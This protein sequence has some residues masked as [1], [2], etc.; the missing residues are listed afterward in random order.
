[1]RNES[2]RTNQAFALGRQMTVEYYECD[3]SVLADGEL[4]EKIFLRAAEKSGAHI[5][6]SNFHNFE[7]QGVSGVVVISESH[8]AVHAWPEHDYAAVDIFTCGESI[9]FEVAIKA[10]Q[11]GMNAESVIVSGVMNRGIVSN[12]GME[13]LVPL[14]EDDSTCYSLSWKS[15][16]E[17]VSASGISCSIDIYEIF[18]GNPFSLAEI[19]EFAADFLQEN[20]LF[21]KLS[22]TSSYQLNGDDGNELI[23]F[24]IEDGI[25]NACLRFFPDAHEVYLDIFSPEYFEP[26]SIAELAIKLLCGKHY[27]MQVAIRR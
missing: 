23:M 26:R 19:R 1:M 16:F 22:S 14:Y 12:N 11:E 15:R 10:L 27:R 21:S 7:P 13:R 4:M 25:K 6:S 5:I 8:F 24:Y 20:E 9:D 18:G 2:V 3:P 17:A